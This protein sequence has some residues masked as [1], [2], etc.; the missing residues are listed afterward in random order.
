[1]Y[2]AWL[3]WNGNVAFWY[4]GEYGGYNVV[5]GHREGV[6]HVHTWKTVP[7]TY[8]TVHHDAEYCDWD[9]PFYVPVW[10]LYCEACNETIYT[11]PADYEA[12]EYKDKVFYDYEGEQYCLTN[13]KYTADEIVAMLDAKKKH[14]EEHPEC[15]YE[16]KVI[17]TEGRYTYFIPG[18]FRFDWTSKESAL[19][20]NEHHHDL[21][22]EAYDE[23]VL[24]SC[25]YTYCTGCGERL[26]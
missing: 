14:M 26:W 7:D 21:M 19:L 22:I 18:G 10:S 13:T 2:G 23:S 15:K 3:Y 24:E 17:S 1:M 9:E 12:R 16:E 5:G 25:G 6:A 8:K 11:L 20:R 4:T